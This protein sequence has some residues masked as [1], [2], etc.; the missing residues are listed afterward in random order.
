MRIAQQSRR[1]TPWHLWLVALV[2]LFWNAAGA[3]EF[4]M[5]RTHNGWRLAHL[6]PHQIEQI[7]AMPLW[8]QAAWA[9]GAGCAVLGSLLLFLRSAIALWLFVLSLAGLAATTVYGLLLAD[10]LDLADAALPGLVF[11]AAIWIVAVL[12]VAYALALRRGR[13]LR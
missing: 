1:R 10:S 5:I 8:A 11:P 6:A 9:L 13:V 7:A 2:T 3:A 12:M 4:A